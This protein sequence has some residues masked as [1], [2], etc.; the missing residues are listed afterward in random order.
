MAIDI[1]L[2]ALLGPV[3]DG[4]ARNTLAEQARRYVGEGFTS[5]WAAQAIGR[6]IMVADPFLALAVAATV[7]DGVEIGSAIIQAPLYAPLDFA[8]RVLTLHQICGDRLSL[9]VGA[10]SNAKDYGAFGRDPD[11]RFRALPEAVAS[12]RD[13]YRTGSTPN[14]VLSPWPA[15][16]KPPRI[17]H[18]TWGKGV[19]TAARDYDGW[20]ASGHYKTVDEVSE[21]A[22]RYRAAGGGRAIVSTLILDGN[23]DL[24]EFRSR[25]V[26]YADA[27]FDDAVV[28]IAPDGPSA[29]EVRALIG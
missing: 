2:G 29:A 9:G 22:A 23:T 7:T 13:V 26:R 1:R 25:L 15:L 11:N 19:E 21:A 14:G 6:G 10:G 17:F 16:S 27:G 3:V 24:G 18:G 28:M 20:I 8:H 4:A 5:L 12:L